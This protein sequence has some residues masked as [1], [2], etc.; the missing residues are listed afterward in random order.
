MDK[1]TTCSSV[2]DILMAAIHISDFIYEIEQKD[3]E[4]QFIDHVECKGLITYMLVIIL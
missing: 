3:V 4:Q 2:T 1:F